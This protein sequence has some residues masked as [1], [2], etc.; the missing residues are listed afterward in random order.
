MPNVLDVEPVRALA[1]RAAKKAAVRLARLLDLCARP[2]PALRRA[3][4]AL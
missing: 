4:P 3:Q 2:P 1:R